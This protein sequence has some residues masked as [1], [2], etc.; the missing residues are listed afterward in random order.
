MGD[1][2][3][4][5][6]KFAK[7]LLTLRR[8]RPF[9]SAV[10]EV[11]EKNKDNERTPT[12]G[13]SS[14]TLSYNEDFA[15]KL[16]FEDFTFVILHEIAHVALK[17]YTRRENRDPKLWNI[18]C[19][20]YIN[21]L[22]SQEFGLKPGGVYRDS[23]NEISMPK[24][25]LYC[26][27]LDLDEEYAESIYDEFE[28]Q[29][30]ENKDTK[31]LEYTGKSYVDPSDPYRTFRVRYEDY[32]GD[33]IP[34]GEDSNPTLDEQ[35]ANKVISDALVRTDMSGQSNG[36]SNSLYTKS[37]ELLKSKV[38]WKRLLRK[39]LIEA[40]SKD[41]SFSIPDR[42]MYYQ[43]SIYPGQ[44]E[45]EELAVTGLKV[46]IDTSGSISEGDIKYFCGQVYDLTKQFKVDAELVYWDSE[47]QS[48]GDFKEYTEFERIDLCGRGGTDPSVIFNYFDS[49]QCKIKPIV[50]LVFTDGYFETSGIS[51]KQ[52][53]KY[54]DTIWVMTRNS[55]KN[56]KP[57]FG[58]VAYPKYKQ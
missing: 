55:N 25:L 22:L 47:V 33:L 30:S 39:Y 52:R 12:M 44:A 38:D 51:T 18:A 43:K 2:L 24:D 1:G 6:Q 19:D 13:V 9:Y 57:P 16:T 58:I 41:S 31:I 8:V 46:C 42:R 28:R 21:M 5:E 45:Q 20:L 14:D 56:F 11:M 27:S 3:T 40:E 26:S 4:L 54:K 34:D 48:T 29:I 7:V 53:K 32:V 37:K 17:H 49:K 50:C 23:L 35:K 36:S 15:N 10:Y